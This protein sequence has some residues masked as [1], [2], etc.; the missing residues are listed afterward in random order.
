MVRRVSLAPAWVLHTRA[1]RDTSL[2]VEL[3][4]PEHGR[5]GLIA[6]AARGRRGRP[7]L[8]PFQP[9]LASWSQRGEL[10]T[11]S[12]LEA[13][14]CALPLHGMALYAG[15]YC[16]ELL[17]R[18]LAR[19]DEQPGLYV[20]YQHCLQ[21]LVTAAVGPTLRVFEFQLLCELGYGWD[22]DALPAD[23]HYQTD[24]MG[25]LQPAKATQT[26]AVSATTLMA[27]A[28]GELT[29]EQAR[30]LQPLLKQALA[31]HLQAP[32]RTPELL[33]SLKRMNAADKA[34]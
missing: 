31:A 21:A 34:L 16:N 24:A 18:L 29:A 33:R 14:G 13:D 7:L 10:G 26:A 28:V 30:H 12:A 8:Q 11:L 6:R 23:S 15:L 20:H 4:S 32:L 3:F 1:W 19:D 9:L 17:L 22:V 25:Q 2:L 27:L 5:V